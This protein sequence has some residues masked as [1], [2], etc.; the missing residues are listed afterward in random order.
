MQLKTLCGLCGS[1]VAFFAEA[2]PRTVSNTWEEILLLDVDDTE[3]PVALAGRSG[4]FDR[5]LRALAEDNSLET[6]AVEWYQVGWNNGRCVLHRMH[7]QPG[8]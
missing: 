8:S 4:S 1:E 5:V 2:N 3:L 7:F 6:S